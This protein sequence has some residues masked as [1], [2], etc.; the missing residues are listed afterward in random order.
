MVE[1]QTASYALPENKIKWVKDQKKIT[2]KPESYFIEKGLDIVMGAEKI[3]SLKLIGIPVVVFYSG[4]VAILFCLFFFF[5]IPFILTV[6]MLTLG[7]V[8]MIIASVAII[9]GFKVWRSINGKS[10]IKKQ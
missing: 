1:T 3:S 9:Q 7:A 8:V 10:K 4:V 5:Y 2:G 6:L